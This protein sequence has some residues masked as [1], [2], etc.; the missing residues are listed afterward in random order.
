MVI[1]SMCSSSVEDSPRGVDF[2]LNPNRLNVAVSRAKTLSVV[3]GSPK[4][5]AA[6]CQSIREMELVNLM[7][8]LARSRCGEYSFRCSRVMPS[9]SRH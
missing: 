8:R 6:R 1:V 7:C 9:L 2:L 4:L 5:M 3:V